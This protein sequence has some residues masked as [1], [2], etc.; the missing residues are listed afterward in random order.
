MRIEG[1]LTV[2]TEE[3][4]RRGKKAHQSIISE[5]KSP[6]IFHKGGGSKN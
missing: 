3:E 4:S 6:G 2:L 1:Y 5:D